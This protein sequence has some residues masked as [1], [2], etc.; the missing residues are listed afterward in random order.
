MSQQVFLRALVG[1]TSAAYNDF[2]V[3]LAFYTSLLAMILMG[4]LAVQKVGRT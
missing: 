4:G 1:M 3:P 2:T